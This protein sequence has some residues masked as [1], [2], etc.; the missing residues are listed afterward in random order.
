MAVAAALFT[1]PGAASKLDGKTLAHEVGSILSRSL[2]RE[3]VVMKVG[4]S[5]GVPQNVRKASSI[6]LANLS[7]PT[8][9]GKK[10][11]KKKKKH[12]RR[13][14]K[15]LTWDDIPGVHGV[16][17][18]DKTKPI[19]ELDLGDLTGAMGCKVSLDI[20]LGCCGGR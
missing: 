15:A 8:H 11:R 14:G 9:G 3:A 7:S 18:F 5:N 20:G 4:V 19:H 1:M 6:S 12:I 10:K 16:L 13:G 17:V 2:A